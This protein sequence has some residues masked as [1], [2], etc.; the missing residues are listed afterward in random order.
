MKNF[1]KKDHARTEV[2]KISKFG[3]L[4][5]VRQKIRSP[6]QLGSYCPCP[7]CHGRGVVMSVEALALADL[8]RI[9]ACLASSKKENSRVLVLE[10]P[11]AVA[12]YL[13]NRKRL[14]LYNLEKN[15]DVEIRVEV[16][17]NLGLEEYKLYFKTDEAS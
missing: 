2:A 1:L 8:R 14:E 7:H 10:A 16:N 17:I 6:V 4:E 11:S 13:L 15:F 12:S 5:L 9:S 3:V